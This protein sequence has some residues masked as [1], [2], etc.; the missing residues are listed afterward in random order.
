MSLS[1]D[2]CILTVGCSAFLAGVVFFVAAAATIFYDVK[3]LFSKSEMRRGKQKRKSISCVCKNCAL[4]I[5]KKKL[6]I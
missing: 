2:Q 1:I 3:F 5:P 6:L 4:F